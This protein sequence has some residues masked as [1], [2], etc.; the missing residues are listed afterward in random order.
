VSNQGELRDAMFRMRLRQEAAGVSEGAGS[1][2]TVNTFRLIFSGLDLDMNEV[3]VAKR[4]VEEAARLAIAEGHAPAFIAGGMF[5]EGLGV[6][7]LI[8]EA[9]AKRG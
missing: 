1:P 6:G 4:G 5:L 7:I 2:V 8:G 9:R 3:W